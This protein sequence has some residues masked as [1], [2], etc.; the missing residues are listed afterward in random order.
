MATQGILRLTVKEAVL[1]RD[2]GTEDDLVMDPYV[3]VNNKKHSVR[4]HTVENG[5]K[6]PCW[7]EVIELEVTN[8]SDDILLRVMDENIATNAEIG[9]C[10]I[11]LGAMCVSGGLDNSWPIA[12]GAYR[13]GRI[14]LHGEWCPTGSDP[15]SFSASAKPGLQQTVAQ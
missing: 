4:T 5:G 10:S 15:V 8:I 1:E 13:A 6:T 7:N 14:H 12:F 3:V 9:R 2:V 11:K